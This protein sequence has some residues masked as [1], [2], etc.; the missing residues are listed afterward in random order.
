MTAGAERRAQIP[1]N[2]ADVRAARAFHLELDGWK[3]DR[4][5]I[6]A[7]YRYFH[8]IQLGGQAAPR[9]G[10]RALAIDFLG[11][12]RGRPL[13]LRAGKRLEGRRNALGRKIAPRI[14]PPDHSP[15]RISGGGESVRWRGGL[16]NSRQS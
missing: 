12:E 8:G 16:V 1:R 14:G 9:T 7:Q 10:V 13:Q 2:R 3:V 11:G 4:D 15:P 5:E 6:E